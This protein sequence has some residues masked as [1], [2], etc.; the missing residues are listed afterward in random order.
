MERY[1]YLIVGA[2]FAGCTLAERLAG[3]L[4]RRVLLIDKRGH[5]GGNCFDSDNDQ[6]IRIQNY[7]PHIFHTNIQRVWDYLNQFTTFNH[8][9]HRVLTHVK[10]GLDVYFPINLETMEQVTG[11]TFTPETLAA[12]FDETRIK[13]D[14]ADIRN[15]RDVVLSQVGEEVYELFV[16]HY[17]RKQWGVYPEELDPQVLRR[18]PVRFNRDTRYFD[19]PWQGIPTH[20]FS[21][22]FETM[23]RHPNID[24]RLGTSYS[25]IVSD[26][27]FDT[28]IY[29]G[30]IDEY[31]D[32]VYGR[33]PYRTMDFKF[34]TLDAEKFQDAAVVNYP[35]DHAYIRITEYK[36]FYFQNHPQT[37]ISYEFPA[38]NGE[39]YYPVPRE[40]NARLYE[41][42]KAAAEKLKNVYFVGRLAEYKYLN[43]D[44][45][46]NNALALVE[47]L[48]GRY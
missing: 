7:G 30:P 23:T 39:P 13:I 4:N 34:E 11:R 37:T 38:E 47:T 31:F 44:Q 25:E 6:G 42:Y 15:S 45:T 22:L 1:H 21:H 17:T 3:Q 48:A 35:N 5:I 36:H 14:E 24:I 12:Y 46:V 28:L 26:I 40:E 18:I 8:Y 20:G 43:M 41:Q 16:R 27:S 33:L 32:Y 29:T 19:D 10:T 2:G 9:I